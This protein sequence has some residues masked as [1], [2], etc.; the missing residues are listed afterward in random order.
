MVRLVSRKKAEVPSPEEHEHTM[1]GRTPG[2]TQDCSE[3]WDW[4][5]HD[6]GDADISQEGI[7]PLGAE[8]TGE[9][10]LA[11]LV[12]PEEKRHKFLECD[13]AGCR[14]KALL[15]TEQIGKH[16]KMNTTFMPY[17]YT[18]MLQLDIGEAEKAQLWDYLVTIG[19]T[20]VERSS[21]LNVR[22]C[23]HIFQALIDTRE[24]SPCPHNDALP[25]SDQWHPAISTSGETF[26]C[27]RLEQEQIQMHGEQTK[28]L[29]ERQCRGLERVLQKQH[30]APALENELLQQ[31]NE[32]EYFS[33][34][35]LVASYL[36]VPLH[37]TQCSTQYFNLMD[38]CTS[39]K[40][41]P[42]GINLSVCHFIKVLKAALRPAVKSYATIYIDDV[43]A[44]IIYGGTPPNSQIVFLGH[45][46][47][48]NRIRTDP[49]R[50]SAIM[51]FPLPK[52]RKQLR[53]YL[54]I[55]NYNRKFGGK[56]ADIIVPLHIDA[57]PPYQPTLASPKEGDIP[58]GATTYPPNEAGCTGA[59][60]RENFDLKDCE[61]CKQDRHKL[62][63]RRKVEQLVRMYR[64]VN[65]EGG[66]GGLHCKLSKGV[67]RGRGNN[68]EKLQRVWRRTEQG[69]QSMLGRS[70]REWNVLREELV[71][72]RG[73]GKFRK[74]VEKEFVG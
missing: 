61:K 49:E 14:I 9:T 26:M 64:V 4:N 39:S 74:G 29:T 68:S 52:S 46:I 37:V 65:E 38:V 40:S 6:E 41:L 73:V 66:W 47:E 54:G 23:G 67:F 53:K 12:L 10:L 31:F 36:Q 55:L 62:K 3:R 43:V 18:K 1:V 16:D 13:T 33:C 21:A 60:S 30:E 48:V 50:V 20:S 15:A 58:R 22:I 70:V 72:V 8:N 35:D 28:P 17:K 34:I 63:D 42:F 57:T 51:E 44:G 24:R 32:S 45:T 7:V 11:M 2:T 5:F 25:V 71:S 69:R 19:H 27:M 56:Y 59:L